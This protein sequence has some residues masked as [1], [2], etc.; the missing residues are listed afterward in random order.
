MSSNDLFVNT[1]WESSALPAAWPAAL[2]RAR[3]VIVPSRFVADVC[4]ASGV[5]VPIEVIPEGIDS[6]I[7]GFHDRPQAGR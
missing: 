7:Y 3:A 6:D 2:N 5:T 4:R 1:M